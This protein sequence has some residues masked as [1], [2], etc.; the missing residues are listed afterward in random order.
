MNIKIPTLKD[1]EAINNLAIQVHELHVTWRPDLFN[2]V[3]N[4]ITKE[5]LEEMIENKEIY[6]SIID[7]KIV[8]YIIFYI[9]EKRNQPP[10]FRYRKQL[11]ID[12]MCV[13][14]YY[15]GKGIGTKL[16]NF[17]K[18]IGIEN[19]CTDIYLTVNEENINAIKT[20]EKFGM[21]VKNIAYS[22]Q[23]NK[24]DGNKDE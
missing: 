20:Y 14:K 22:I 4:V 11:N 10:K 8:G 9:V 12:A 18:N 17:A 2:S 23:L 5:E 16:L 13:D 6:V 7:N 15:R 24:K 3:K 19:N 1:Y 21:K